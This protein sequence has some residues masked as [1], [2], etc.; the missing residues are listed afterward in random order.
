MGFVPIVIFFVLINESRD[1]EFIPVKII[2]L[3]LK[4]Q[5]IHKKIICIL[6]IQT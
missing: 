2:T 3:Y 6:I 1:I 5:D 4:I